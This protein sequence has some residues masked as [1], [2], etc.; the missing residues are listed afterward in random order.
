MVFKMARYLHHLHGDSIMV[1]LR[2]AKY[3]VNKL[4][5]DK[6]NFVNIMFYDCFKKLILHDK[7]LTLISYNP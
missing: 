7:G 3:A 5:I 4:L 6:R 2:V 1:K